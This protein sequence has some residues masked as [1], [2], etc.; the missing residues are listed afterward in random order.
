M[1]T[2]GL[3]YEVGIFHTVNIF[4]LIELLAL[5]RE[6]HCIYQWS[7]KAIPKVFLILNA[8]QLISFFPFRIDIHHFYDILRLM[9]LYSL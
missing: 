5:V 4:W 2:G 9:L 8:S 7:V 1:A 3:S 6:E